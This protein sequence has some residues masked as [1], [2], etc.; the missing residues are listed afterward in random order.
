MEDADILI[1]GGGSAGCVLASRLSEDPKRRVRLVEMGRDTPPDALP[2]DVR[3]LFP[4]AYANPAYFWP[5]LKAVARAGSPPKPYSQARILGGGST[6]MGLWALRGLPADYDAWAAAGADG[7][8]FADVLPYFIRLETDRNIR[9]PEHGS[10][11]PVDIRR[12]PYDGWPGF[13]RALAA[14][15]ARRG[16][17]LR[18]DL[19]A[20]DID[21]VFAI[22]T[23]TDGRQRVSATTAYLTPAARRRD[24][25][26]IITEATA[27]TILFEGRKAVGAIVARPD[28]STATLRA[29]EIIVSAGALHSPH[30]LLKSGIG[31]ANQL[32]ACGVPVVAD[33]PEVGANLQNHIF[34]HLGA[35]IR[36]QARQSPK[37]RN[38]AMAGARLSSGA[39]GAPPGDLFVSFIARTSGYATG[40][41]LGMVGPSLYAP[42]S[43]GSVRLDRHNPGGPPAVDFN[44]LSDRRDAERLVHAARFARA[45][46]LDTEVRNATHEA[47]VLPP[48]P[49]IRLLNSPGVSSALLNLALAA[50]A[51][52]GALPRKA[53]LRA[54]LR[55]GKLL[56]DIRS[57]EE[58]AEL[59]LAGATPMFHPAGTCAIGAVVDAQARVIGVESLRV[60]DAS[61]MPTIPRGNTNIPTMMLAEKCA[62]GMR[63]EVGA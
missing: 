44:L 57:D 39:D 38:Y 16:L 42:F 52:L 26:D 29:R 59:A 53:A 28:G 37:L 30:L 14:A 58:F 18:P 34:L 24:N 41:R 47:F 5:D 17:D 50:I 11:G 33:A 2:D 36:P 21:G 40:N 23:S 63:G 8:S 19:N 20:R 51:G 27:Q 43:R 7:W 48:S 45:L 32:A 62:A 13:N 35:V 10:D 55:P 6:V 1:I 54:V 25:L 60:V 3:D 46:F 15:A 12:I 61:I 56:V 9:S 31:P 49:P 22:P 4:R